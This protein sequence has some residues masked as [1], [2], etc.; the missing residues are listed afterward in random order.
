MSAEALSQMD[1]TSVTPSAEF[2]I[3]ESAAKP[4]DWWSS[5][6]IASTAPYVAR[7]KVESY[8]VMS[9]L[10]CPACKTKMSSCFLASKTTSCDKCGMECIPEMREYGAVIF[11][12][13]DDGCQFP[14][15]SGKA[16]GN[17]HRCLKSMQE[18]PRT[19]N[20]T[21]YV[22]LAVKMNGGKPECNVLAVMPLPSAAR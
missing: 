17:A 21:I 9:Y 15:L 12:A 22:Q 7:V 8:A 13:A 19:M 18:D 20:V 14:S 16:W 2:V 6:P 10:A 5:T 4:L 11:H 1:A 3:S